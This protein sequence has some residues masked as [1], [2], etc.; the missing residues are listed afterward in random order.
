MTRG[1][2][3]ASLVASPVLVGAVTVLV[4]IIAVFIA[5]NANQGL[6]FVPT[7]DINMEIPGGANLVKGN[8]VRV[9]G[10][11]V[12]LVDEIN[13]KV[14]EDPLTGRR[15]SIALV[16][17]KLDKKIEPLP[18]DSTFSTRPRSARTGRNPRTGEPIQIKAS[19]QPKFRP[20]KV[21]KDAV[22]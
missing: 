19:S 17:V 22:Q 8:E 10:F 1:R 2:G 7:Y 5:Y 6:P 13:P 3:T 11:R 15:R 18:A 20:G 9:G 16:H 14:E 12:G 21:L 4:A